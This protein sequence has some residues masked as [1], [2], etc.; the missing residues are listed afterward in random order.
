M[1]CIN[2]FALLGVELHGWEGTECLQHTKRRLTKHLNG[3]QQV[4]HVMIEANGLVH[5]MS[6]RLDK[7][8][9]LNHKLPFP[10]NLEYAY[11]AQLGGS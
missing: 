2:L 9:T 8:N 7:P 6:Q 1:S 3:L 10:F 11:G 5:I 4:N